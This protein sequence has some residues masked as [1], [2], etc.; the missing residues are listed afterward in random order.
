MMKSIYNKMW[1]DALENI[2]K[3]ELDLDPLIDDPNDSRRGITLQAKPD[4]KIL[5]NFSCFLKEAQKIEPEQYFYRQDEIH[6]TV[7]SIINCK[8]GFNLSD[9]RLPDYI[10]YIQKG[11]NNIK[12][13]TIK[14][15]GITA[16]PSCILIQ[17]F[18]EN[19]SL[20][21]VR[22]NLRAEFVSGDLNNSIDA[23][24]RIYTAH[25]TVIRFKKKL[26]EKQKFI[27]LLENYRNYYFG[28][29]CINEMELVHTDWYH[30][31]DIVQVM[32]KFKL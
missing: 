25:C 15:N 29:T 14:F 11:I 24:Y 9:I 16:S 26:K 3:N 2:K 1:T 4:K 8:I 18:P 27:D 21:I 13:F 5:D 19:N 10:R 23:R 32:H 22:D 31:N 12:P 7:L 17:G 28:K 20:N 30:K 6:I